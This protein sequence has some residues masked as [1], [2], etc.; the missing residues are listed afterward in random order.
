MQTDTQLQSITVAISNDH[1][2]DFRAW[3]FNRKPRLAPK[4]INIA[5]QH[6]RVFSRWHQDKFNQAFRPANITNYDLHLYRAYSLDQQKVAARTWNS[7]RWALDLLCQWISMPELMDG[8]EEKNAGRAS[9]KHRSLTDNE[10]HRLIHT[11]ETNPRRAQTPFEKHNSARDYAAIILMLHGLRVEEVSLIEIGDITIN[12]RSGS[13]LVRNGKGNKEREVRINLIGRKALASYLD[14]RSASAT[15]SLF[16]VRTVRSLQR[17]VQ[18]IGEQIGVPDLTP[19]WLRYT[20]AKRLERNNIALETIR[21][22]LGHS[23]IEQTKRYL[24]SSAEELQSAVEMV[25]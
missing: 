11:L 3:L 12:E 4:S 22:L 8:I 17:D 16:A 20:F 23:T 7:R 2:N 5:A 24:R 19:H 13:V 25:M 14:L 15:E 10:Y 1:E 6:I 9:T 21:D 18:T